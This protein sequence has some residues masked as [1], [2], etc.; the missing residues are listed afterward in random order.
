MSRNLRSETI[1]M[2]ELRE[3]LREHGIENPSE[4]KRC[5]L[6]PDGRLSVIKSD[7]GELVKEEQRSAR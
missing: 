6:E 7:K 2:D 1:T 5:Q 4:A 3:H